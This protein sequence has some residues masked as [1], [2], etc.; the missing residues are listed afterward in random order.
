MPMPLFE[1]TDEQRKFVRTLV[2]YGIPQD[3]IAR[4]VIDS[5]G[6]GIDSKT[7]RKHFRA[8]M[9]EAVVEANSK[10]AETLY[11]MAVS[12]DCPAATFFWLKCRA[13]WR[14]VQVIE[15]HHTFSADLLLAARARAGLIQL[16]AE[17]DPVP[18]QADIDAIEHIATH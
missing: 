10:V 15:Q 1:P 13:R 12:G 18:D 7:L 6:S 2:A 9:D 5:R 17:A 3:A 4:L 14:E 8:E 16:P 11:R